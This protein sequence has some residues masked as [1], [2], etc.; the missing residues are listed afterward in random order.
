MRYA[1]FG[2]GKRLRPALAFGAALAC[3]EKPERVL[4]VAA[5]VELVHAYSLVH[6]DL[7]AMDDDTLRRGR[8]TVHVE[9]GE[10]VAILVGDAL[11]TEAFGVL[12]RGSVPLEVIESLSRLAGSRALVGGQAEDLAFRS[13]GAT[14]ATVCGIHA[15]KTAALFCFAVAGAAGTVAAPPDVQ[16]CLARFAENYG[17]AFQLT[18]DLLDARTDECSILAVLPEERA[19]ERL[20][21]R[22]QAALEALAPLGL[23]AEALRG[24]AEGLPLRLR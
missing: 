19:R 2:G 21:E 20:E 13:E 12:A 9:Y 22:G 23:A 16:A 7:P 4:P 14:E 17:L 3:G 10:A 24:L 11:L 6:D 1:V 15:Q 5:A 18:D 8:N